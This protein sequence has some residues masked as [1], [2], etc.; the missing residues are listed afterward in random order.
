M[1]FDVIVPRHTDNIFRMCI[2][3]KFPFQYVVKVAHIEKIVATLLCYVIGRCSF[4]QFVQFGHRIR[5]HCIQCN[6]ASRFGCIVFLYEI[7]ELSACSFVA[8]QNFVRRGF[9][10]LDLDSIG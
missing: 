5:F 1:N 8:L 4:P 7:D 10:G 6:G 2:Q 3:R 9:I